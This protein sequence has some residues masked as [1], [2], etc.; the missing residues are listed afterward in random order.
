MEADRINSH[1]SQLM[2][3]RA[4]SVGLLTAVV[5]TA[6]AHGAVEPW[7]VAGFELLVAGLILLWGVKVIVEK[8]VTIRIPA[9]GLPLVAL[10]ALA[11][12]QSLAITDHLGERLSFSLDVE[13][14]RT[15]LL[16]LSCLFVSFLIAANFFGSSN[17]KLGLANFL[18]G[19]GLALAVFALLQHFTWNGRFYWL[20]T[21]TARNA[22]P[23]GPFVNRNHF[24][25]YM[26]MLAPLPI[27]MVIARAPGRDL[28]L[29]YVF[30]AVMM[31]M[32]AIVSLSRGGMISLGAELVFIAAL[33]ARRQDV[34]GRRPAEGTARLASVLFM[35]RSAALILLIAGVVVA[36]VL[37]MAPNQIVD[38]ITSQSAGS[39]AQQAETLFSSRGWV[40]R[41]TI[42]MIRAKPLMGVGLGAYETAYPIYSQ[43]DGAVALGRSYA[44]DRAHNDYLQ[45][46]TEGGIVGGVLAL[47]FIVSIF[48]AVVRGAKSNDSLRRAFAIGGGAGIF[49]ILVHSLVDFNLQLP[50][51]ALLFLLL[52]AA[53]TYARVAKPKAQPGRKHVTR[54]SHAAAVAIGA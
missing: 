19:W 36:G 47:W 5:F 34:G 24:A 10:V 14:T 26:E 4:I 28:R 30:A 49:G 11:L 42:A 7:A 53:V 18:I 1:I 9:V 15:T 51:N 50:S 48:R 8:K 29:L 21:L 35:P 27:A 31:A 17:R 20:R 40:W 37:W 33:S 39:Q 43:D 52:V 12:V 54:S 6:L 45:L 23:F 46:V 2:F 3:D 25:G 16:T 41:D 38:R 13:A 22:M 44:V 32:A